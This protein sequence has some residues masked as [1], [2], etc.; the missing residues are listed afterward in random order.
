[1]VGVG[2]LAAGKKA[3]LAEKALAAGDRERHHDAVAYPELFVLGSDL[4]DFAHGFVAEHVALFHRRHDAIHQMEVRPANRARC[5]LDNRIATV[6]D[7]GIRHAIAPDV[8][9]AMPSQRFHRCLLRTARNTNAERKFCSLPS[10]EEEGREVDVRVRCSTTPTRRESMS[11]TRTFAIVTGASTGIGFELAKRCAK[12]GYDLLIAADERTIEQAAT[13]LRG[14]GAEVDAIQADLGTTE[15]VDKL[16]A[17]AKGPWAMLSSTRI[18]TR[19]DASL[20]P[21]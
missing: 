4:D 15:G 5:H 20:T 16:Y 13:S 19:P 6:L 9:L 12:D 17:A 18:S 2:A 10:T 8:V 21:T 1:V 14:A 3:V 7:L 11:A